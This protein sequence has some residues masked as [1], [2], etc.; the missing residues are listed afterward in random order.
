MS[1]LHGQENDVT[2]PLTSLFDPRSVAIVGASADPRKWGHWLAKGA[3]A[4][5]ERRSVALVNRQR[6]PV[7]GVATSARVSDLTEVPELVVVTTPAAHVHDVVEESLALGSRFFVVIT[8]GIGDPPTPQAERELAALVRAGGGRLLGPNCMGVVDSAASLQLSW[9]DFPRGEVGL[10]SQSGNVGLELARML[11]A[12][13]LGFSRFVSLGNQGDLDAADAIESMALHESTRLIAAYV[14]DFR[15]GRRLARALVAAR[16][17]G[18]PVLLLTVGGSEASTRAAQSHTGAMVSAV[19]VVDAVCAH[20]GAL[21]VSGTGELVDVVQALLA[22]QPIVGDRVSVVADSG[23]QGALAAD[24]LTAR[25]LQVPPLTAGTTGSLGATLP[26]YAGLSNPVDLAGAGEADLNSYAEVV[27]LLQDGPETTTTLLTGYFGSY[28][29]DT[30]SLGLDE[31][32]VATALAGSAVESG[33][34]VV[35][36]SM[37][38]GTPALTVLRELGVPVYPRV[39]QAA[40]GVAG[41]ATWTARAANVVPRLPDAGPPLPTGD[42][43]VVRSL[44]LEHGVP[45]ADAAFGDG[46]DD[47]LL[48]AEAVGFPV[49]LKAMGL[50]HKTEAGGV[51]LGIADRAALAV[52]LSSMRARTGATHYAVEAMATWPGSVELIM[53]V[54]HDPAFGPVAMVGIGGTAAELAD[55]TALGLAPL[56]LARARS[57]IESLRHAPLLRGWRGASAVDLEAAATVL[58]AVAEAAASHPE[59]AELEVNPVLVHREG[60]VALDA[61]A[62]LRP[63][64]TRPR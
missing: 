27:R 59:L 55:D 43:E 44:L 8:T 14:E 48:A 33:Q 53:G 5:R 63:G 19:D 9:G 38:S 51:A 17:A 60:A 6:T 36:H 37:A 41:A 10:V 12:V 64:G 61:A 21:R 18:K 15:D 52:A 54:R 34:A 57:M 30:P 13:G 24:A 7:L 31:L 29:T 2:D 26:S 25:G 40:A 56:T 16:E 50:L 28:G 62:T 58:V 22:R 20:T 11:G 46:G 32:A 35:V 4:G 42:Y 45:F 47:F 23:G 1:R 3:L 39:E 49:A